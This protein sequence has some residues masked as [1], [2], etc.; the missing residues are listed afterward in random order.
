M[1]KKTMGYQFEISPEFALTMLMG[2][3][4]LFV[5]KTKTGVF[6][7]FSSTGYVYGIWVV[8]DT[9][10]TR[11]QI[12]TFYSVRDGQEFSI[13]GKRYLG[14]IFLPGDKDIVHLFEKMH[15]NSP[16][17]VSSLDETPAADI[18]KD[19]NLFSKEEGSDLE[20]QS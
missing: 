8:V 18:P 4:I 14:S 7:G 5:E 3:E 6:T 16:K 12:R 20:K 11:T 17:S 19:S 13:K 2:A 9:L 15:I 10:E 1:T